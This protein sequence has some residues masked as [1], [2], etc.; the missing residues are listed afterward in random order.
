MQ[1]HINSTDFLMKSWENLYYK[2][3]KNICNFPDIYY[4]NRKQDGI[5]KK[6]IEYQLHKLN[7]NFERVEA[8]TP[9]N[10]QLVKPLKPFEIDKRT[11]FNDCEYCV[12]LSHL[13]CL[14]MA[15]KKKNK[16]SSWKMI[17]VSFF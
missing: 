6:F 5:R 3:K 4:I 1:Y 7:L 11:E 12:T 2:V 15:F 9:D 10:Y 8:V 16:L 13:K 14:Y 17:V